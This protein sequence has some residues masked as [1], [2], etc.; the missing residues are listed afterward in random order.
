MLL[1]SK[2]ILKKLWLFVAKKK[3]KGKGIRRCAAMHHI[4][5]NDVFF[6]L[7]K[8]LL[9]RKRFICEL[10]CYIHYYFHIYFYTFLLN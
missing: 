7:F 2:K 1:D 4:G 9:G 6:L 5:V 10:I 8:A 3:S